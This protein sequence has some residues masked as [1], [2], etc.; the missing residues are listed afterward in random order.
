LACKAAI[1][2]VKQRLHRRIGLD[3]RVSVHVGGRIKNLLTL[4]GVKTHAGF[5]YP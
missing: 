2:P 5:L 3:A 1:F 4:A